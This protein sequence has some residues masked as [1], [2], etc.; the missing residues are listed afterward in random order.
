MLTRPKTFNIHK[1]TVLRILIREYISKATHFLI[2]DPKMQF[3]YVFLSRSGVRVVTTITCP[4]WG[5]DF[6]FRCRQGG[7][8]WLDFS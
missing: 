3:I 7:Q 2:L 6:D 1:P 5:P 4:Y 8:L